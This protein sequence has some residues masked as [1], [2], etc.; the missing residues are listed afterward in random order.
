[1]ESACLG[2]RFCGAYGIHHPIASAGMAFVASVPELAIAVA[3]AGGLPAIG[4]GIMSATH[5][6]SC[7]ASYRCAASAPLNVNFLTFA[8]D[9]EKLALCCALKPEII[10]FHWGH[11][12]KSWIEALHAAGI[13][14]WEQVGSVAAA[15]TAFKDG[16]D[17]V[18][19]QGLE[20]GG[21]NYAE[22]PLDEAVAAVRKSLGPDPMLLAAGGISDGA[23][24]ARVMS[25]GADGVMLGSRLVASNEANAHDVYK[26]ALVASDGSDTVLTSLFGREMPFF[27]PVRV[28]A[29][30]IVREWHGREPELPPAGDSFPTIGKI[31]TPSGNLPI[32]QL[33]SIVP[34]RSAEGDIAGMMLLAGQGIG[35][36]Q[37]IESVS[38]II[39][40]MIAEMRALTRQTTTEIL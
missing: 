36:I 23:K 2:T 24:I 5:L 7:V 34:T 25:L 1:M 16:V 11:P 39:S 12:Q 19:V 17:L 32:R 6:E 18:I 29:N 15:Q 31:A 40:G 30:A 13:K 38:I 35:K 10:S 22:L 14:V 26:A 28:I 8:F 37:S 27:N 4:A 3:N 33:D 20:A 9:A 21:H